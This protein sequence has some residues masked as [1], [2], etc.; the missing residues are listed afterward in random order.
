[1][2]G[3]GN[4]A[5][6]IYNFGSPKMKQNRPRKAPSSFKAQRDREHCM[7][8]IDIAGAEKQN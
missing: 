6:F 3:I 7:D 5:L 4:I 8:E 2:C 1:V